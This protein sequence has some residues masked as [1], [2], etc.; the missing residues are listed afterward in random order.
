MEK[1]KDQ[2]QNQMKNE[3]SESKSNEISENQNQSATSDD[4]IIELEKIM[5]DKLQE[6]FRPK[7]LQWHASEGN[8][9][10]INFRKF[11]VYAEKRSQ[12]HSTIRI[13][14][15]KQKHRNCVPV[16]IKNWMRKRNRKLKEVTAIPSK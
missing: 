9:K 16:E 4:F 12:K 11:F 3:K 15:R 8:R 7:I 2:N 14:L 5:K 6:N 13:A 10:I 1:S